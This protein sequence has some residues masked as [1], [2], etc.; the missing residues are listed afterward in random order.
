MAFLATLIAGAFFLVGALL[1]FFGKNRKGLV[2]FSIGMAFS[3]ML[4]L[5]AFD[6]V[7]EV[8]ELL[9][10]KGTIFMYVFIVIGIVTLKLIDI[11]VPHHDHDEEIKTH[12]RHL[13]HIGIISSL[14]LIVHNV[15]E[16][17][18][19]FN[20]AFVDFIAGQLL[21]IALGIYN[22]AL[23][24]F[25][26]GLLMAIGVG[27]HNIPFGI[28]ITATLNETKKNKTSVF[29]NILLLALSTVFGA[30]IMM[31]FKSIDDFIL[32]SLMSLTIGMIIYLVLFELL[33]E[34]GTSKNKKYSTAGLITG[35][36]FM[37]IIL[38]IGG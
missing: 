27:L 24:D 19:L 37:V 15:I 22:I 17:V 33:T 20:I 14:A 9:E 26:A 30:I 7:P 23:V 5:L 18:G 13:K 3:V 36:L 28:E 8:L 25:K 4:L 38:I 11:L 35:V 29:L 21:D 2:E 12:D 16:G 31:I 32:G 6:I 10:E 1:A 34:L